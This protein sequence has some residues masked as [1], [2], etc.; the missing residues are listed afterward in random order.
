MRKFI[1][2]LLVVSMM[3]FTSVS[4]AAES[5]IEKFPTLDELFDS[6]FM[7][8]GPSI[9]HSADDDKKTEEQKPSDNKDG[10]NAEK[11]DEQKDT[12]IKVEPVPETEVKPAPVPEQKPK[13]DV[14]ANKKLKSLDLIVILDRSGSM[15]GLENDTIGGFNSMVEEQKRL[16]IPVSVSLI[17]FNNKVTTLYEKKALKDVETLL[18]AQYTASGTTALYDAVGNTLSALQSNPDVFAEGHKNLVVIT[19]DG[20]E[21][22]SSEWTKEKVRKLIGDLREKNFEFVFLGADINASDVGKSMG[23]AESNSVKFKKTSTGVRSNFKAVGA[24]MRTLVA[25]DSLVENADWK[26][27]IER[28]ND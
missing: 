21:N 1:T 10:E 22:A 25:G 13:S 6:I 11:K 12:D 7:D 4:F 16:E 18:R 27:S 26:N 8:S 15:Y 24:M 17:M 20:Y 9:G 5:S 28:D 3:M 2:S 19:T 23:I 14:E